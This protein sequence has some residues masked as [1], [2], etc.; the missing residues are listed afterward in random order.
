MLLRRPLHAAVA[1]LAVVLATLAPARPA[2]A[3]DSCS[4]D[5]TSYKCTITLLTGPVLT[6]VVRL[7][8]EEV[9][10][11]NPKD[12]TVQLRPGEHNVVVSAT[13]GGRTVLL[14]GVTI[15]DEEKDVRTT[16]PVDPNNPDADRKPE[17]VAEASRTYNLSGGSLHVAARGYTE[18]DAVRTAVNVSPA[19][20][21]VTVNLP[22]TGGAA[23]AAPLSPK[24]VAPP[25][26]PGVSR[27]LKDLTL[28]PSDG[29]VFHVRSKPFSVTADWTGTKEVT[30]AWSTKKRPQSNVVDLDGVTPRPGRATVRLTIT[31]KKDATNM[32]TASIELRFVDELLLRAKKVPLYGKQGAKVTWQVYATGG[33]GRKTLAWFVND[34]RVGGAVTTQTADATLHVFG[35]RGDS[36]LAKTLKD[37]Q[38]KNFRVVVTD[39]GLHPTEDKGVPFGFTVNLPGCRPTDEL[40]G[41]RSAPILSGCAPTDDATATAG[42]QGWYWMDYEVSKT[43]SD[44]KTSVEVFKR[45]SGLKPSGDQMLLIAAVEGT[46]L[47]VRQYPDH[48]EWSENTGASGSKGVCTLSA[49]GGTLTAYRG[50]NVNFR[51]SLMSGK[52]AI[53]SKISLGNRDDFDRPGQ[54]SGAT[55]TSVPGASGGGDVGGDAI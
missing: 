6:V 23:A 50:A 38:M 45:R 13:N 3:A 22:I 49:S 31:D 42:Y 9:K 41:F 7:T 30:Y 28:T 40:V 48:C 4:V 36:S 47:Q 34:G 35:V 19:E 27:A 52:D 25:A 32:A 24:A 17:A 37:T 2:A 20:G 21:F 11:I 15:G 39:Q 5:Q 46:V 8:P 33:Y 12:G 51:L 53:D 1:A 26:V 14:E 10:A 29:E 44:G 55:A 18:K 16:P 54:T 43:G